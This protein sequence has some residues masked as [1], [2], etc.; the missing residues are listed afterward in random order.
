MCVRTRRKIK[1]FKNVNDNRSPTQS[2]R[3]FRVQSS[4]C[5]LRFAVLIFLSNRMHELTA[6]FRASNQISCTCINCGPA[7][8]NGSLWAETTFCSAISQNPKVPRPMSIFFSYLIDCY[9]WFHPTFMH[10]LSTEILFYDLKYDDDD[11]AMR[12]IYAA[13]GI[14]STHN[15]STKLCAL[16]WKKK[17]WESLGKCLFVC[18]QSVNPLLAHALEHGRNGRHIGSRV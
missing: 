16:R 13:S 3:C 5:V 18:I 6:L 1:A 11:D 2:S 15:G 8:K 4:P 9:K 12:G 17:F 14:S 7:D 10:I